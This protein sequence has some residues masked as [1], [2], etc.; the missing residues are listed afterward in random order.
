MRYWWL[1]SCLL[2]SFLVYLTIAWMKVGIYEQ[3]LEKWFCIF[4]FSLKYPWSLIASDNKSRT[5]RK[6][7]M[8]CTPNEDNSICLCWGLASS[9]LVRVMSSAV[10]LPNHIFLDRLSPLTSICAQSFSRNWQLPFLNQRKEE[11][12]C[13]KYFMI[14]LH[15]RMLPVYRF[16]LH[17]GQLAPPGVKLWAYAQS[18]ISLCGLQETLH[19]WWFK[20]HLVKILI[21]LCE[22]TGWSESL[23]GAHVW[24]YKTCL[25]NTPLILILMLRLV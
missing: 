11:N 3:K 22:C 23:L 4:L 24:R 21:R 14:S 16:I 10:S 15:E 7:A 17:P 5:M 20:M 1:C 6:G 19:P 12:D 8:T 9:Q 2:I 25:W 18:L 13:R